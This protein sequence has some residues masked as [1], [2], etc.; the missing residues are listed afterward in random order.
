LEFSDIEIHGESPV[1]LNPKVES[2]LRASLKYL[3]Q[4]DGRPRLKSCCGPRLIS[5]L[6]IC[7]TRAFA[8]EHIFFGVYLVSISNEHQRE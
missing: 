3:R 2:L 7:A 4:G 8:L 1:D 6:T 5:I